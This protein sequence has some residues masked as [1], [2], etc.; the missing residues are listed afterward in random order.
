M[1]EHQKARA[2][3]MTDRVNE[4]CLELRR[5]IDDM[6]RDAVNQ[7]ER[8]ATVRGF[9]RCTVRCAPHVVPFTRRRFNAKW[10]ASSWKW[11]RC[12]TTPTR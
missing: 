4:K 11:R 8:F 9:L 7:N 5:R 6:R 12:W 1:L 3:V 10:S 2:T